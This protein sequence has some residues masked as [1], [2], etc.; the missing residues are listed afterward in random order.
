VRTFIRAALASM[1][2]VAFFVGPVSAATTSA[3]T[4]AQANSTGTVSGQVVGDNGNAV[5][6]ASVLFDGPQRQTTTTDGSGNFTISVMPGLYTVTVTK[7]GFQTG[8]SQV[9]VTSDTTTSVNVALTAANLSNLNVIGRTSSSSSSNTAHFNISSSPQQIITQQQIIQRNTPDLTSVLQEL[10]GV[11]IPR[12]T[13]NPNQSFII[14]GLRYETK[15]EIDGHPVSS[16][17]GGT[18]LTNY[19]AA[20]IFGGVDVTSGM[21]LNGPTAAEAGAGIVNLRTPDF[22]AKDSGLLQGGLDNYGGSLYTA[23]ADINIGNKLSVI[24]GRSFSGYRGPSYATQ[25][26]DYTGATPAYGTGGPAS[27]ANGIVQYIADFSNTYSLNAELAKARYEFSNATSLTFE[28]LGLQGSFNPQ[29]GAYGQY[30]GTLTVPQCFNVVNKADVA[31]NGAACTATSTYNSPAAQGEIGA[32]I[33]IYGFYPGSF[34]EQNQPNFNADFKTTIGNDTLLLRPYTAA[35]NRLIDGTQESN[36]PGDN[37]GGWSEV[38]NVANC[39]A[40]YVAPGAGGASGPCF[41]ANSIPGAAYVGAANTVPVT[42]ATTTTAPLCTVTT[43]CYTTSTGLNNSGQTGYGSPYTTLELDHLAG[44]TFD[45]IHP[46]GANTY[47]LS[48]DHYYDDTQS[49]VNDDTPLAAGCSFVLGSGQANTPGTYGYQ[50]TCPLATLRPSPIS[51]PETFS[52][53]SSLAGTAQLQLTSKLEFDAG[54]YFTHYLINAQQ[55]N[56]AFLAAQ[57]AAGA[58]AQG[59]TSAIPVA[60]SGVQN[61]ASHFDPRIGLIFRPDRDWVIRFTTGSAIQIPYASLISGFATYAQGSTSTTITTPNATLLPE[62]IV[63]QDLGSDLRLPDGTVLSGDIYNTVVHNPWINPHVQICNSQASCAV[64]LPGLEQTSAG[65]TSITVNGAQQYAQGINFSITNEPKVGFGYKVNSAVERLYYLDTNPAY[66]ATPQVFFNGDQFQSTG[67]T[68][69]SVPYLKAYGE[70]QY[71]GKDQSLFRIGTDFEGKNNEYN[72]PPFFIW[73]AGLQ[74]NTGFYNVLLGAAVE[75][76][77][78][79]NQALLGRG[80]EYAGTEPITATAVPGGYAY[81][82]GTYNTSLVAP[83]PFTV[84]F[85]L[86]KK[87]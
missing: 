30:L 28:F 81:S 86:T 25:Q 68:T 71:A 75:N 51:V 66:L 15:T 38:T 33:P 41:A 17:T 79:T 21:G 77:F 18:F 83:P 20:P 58:G 5:A 57:T 61:S 82:V 56:P 37:G 35:I 10:P 12:A 84:R 13:S 24:L 6:G 76:L 80:I 11:T 46:V 26:A 2:A 53:V 74:V 34:V 67:S 50:S 44:Y 29:G 1:I 23:L 62:E 32:T 63:T 70:I 19:T 3:I 31:G 64:A 55:E 73:D 36:V 49:F 59:R 14:D 87:F 40:T 54:A 60:L 4:V 72:A 69:T 65:Y 8:S 52:S 45:Y 85:T 9:T 43:P 22:T 78:N 42:Y 7:G 47:N 39:Q 16:G 48:F 27:L